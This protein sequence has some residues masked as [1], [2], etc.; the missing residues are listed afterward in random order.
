MPS[1]SRR[2][3][4]CGGGVHAVARGRRPANYHAKAGRLRHTNAAKG[5]VPCA[6]CDTVIIFCK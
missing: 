2:W 1:A 6:K 3:H 4:W 5:G